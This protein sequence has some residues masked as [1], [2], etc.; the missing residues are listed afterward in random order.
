[1]ESIEFIRRLRRRPGRRFGERLLPIIMVDRIRRLPNEPHPRAQ[2]SCADVTDLSELVAEVARQFYKP[3][4]DDHPLRFQL[5]TKALKMMSFSPG[6]SVVDERTE[7]REHLAGRRRTELAPA[8]GGNTVLARWQDFSTYGF[9]TFSGSAVLGTLATVG[10]VTSTLVYGGIALASL[11]AAMVQL[12]FRLFDAPWHPRYRWFRRQPYLGERGGSL[13]EATLAAPKADQRDKERLV[14]AALLE[15][16]SQAYR[17]PWWRRVGWARVTYPMLLLRE[18]HQPQGTTLLERVEE[19]R[20]RRG[21]TDPLLIVAEMP[22]AKQAGA[23][24]HLEFVERLTWGRRGRHDHRLIGDRVRDGSGLPEGQRRRPRL[25][26]PLVTSITGLALLAMTVTVV[27]VDRS[28]RCARTWIRSEASQCVGLINASGAIPEGFLHPDL[29]PVVTE[30]ERA[31]ATAVEQ[32]RHLTF[33]LFGE[34]TLIGKN[35]SDSRLAGA[36]GELLGLAH[37]QRTAREVPIRLL[38]ANAGDNFA[39]GARTAELVAAYARQDPTFAGVI[40]LG[41]SVRGVAAAIEVLSAAKIPMVVTSATA[42]SVGGRSRYAFRIAAT[43]DREGALL[44]RYARRVL[45]PAER[46]PKAVVVID[47]S[48]A[49]LYSGDL[50]RVFAA[51][52]RKEADGAEPDRVT[53]SELGTSTGPAAEV[54]RRSPDVTFYAGRAPQLL[55]FLKELNDSDCG[56][57]P[58][59]VVAGDDAVKEIADNQGAISGLT[60]VRLLFATFSDRGLTPQTPDFAGLAERFRPV[61]QEQP[62]DSSSDNA[63]MGYAGG[64]LLWRA[65]SQALDARSPLDLG[66]VLYYLAATR[67]SMALYSATGML[68]YGPEDAHEGQDKLVA[69][70]EVGAG[71]EPVRR[72]YCGRPTPGDTG[73]AGPLCAGLPGS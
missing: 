55:N 38:L 35:V 67:G 13:V 57:D 46:R 72:A 40:G 44:V 29:R 10:R 14:V 43:N 70:V 25:A 61:G 30:I 56:R 2:V 3:R 23:K 69:V 15:D 32:G 22:R 39:Q 19:V 73:G 20:D 24:S 9:T 21:G 59:L 18:A 34:Y 8:E 48:T 47:D 41:R 11:A 28:V 71:G 36:F 50:G 65:A 27:L 49:E 51:E 63:A 64:R 37:L 52:F 45:L 42:A 53:Y 68:S 60:K 33:V 1:M 17:R 62:L 4:G 31:N 16:L 54:C 6:R 58:R 7:A 12:A 66:D 5:T 26:H